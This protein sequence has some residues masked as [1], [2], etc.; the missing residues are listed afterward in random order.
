MEE[1]SRV[2]PEENIEEVV[3]ADHIETAQKTTISATNESVVKDKVKSSS[4]DVP[5]LAKVS[6][7]SSSIK[8][9]AQ[10]DDCEI[11]DVSLTEKNNTSVEEVGIFQSL[12]FK[13]YFL[14]L[15][16]AIQDSHN[17]HLSPCSM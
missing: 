15:H 17:L 12:H 5:N 10:D 7:K 6:T 8:S 13:N 9:S 3:K 2:R 11:I 14:S 4:T 1:D 16:S